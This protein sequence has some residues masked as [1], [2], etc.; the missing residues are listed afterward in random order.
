[1]FVIVCVLTLIIEC[2]KLAKNIEKEGQKIYT[3]IAFQEK[4][5]VGLEDEL[6]CTQI[7]ICMYNFHFQSITLIKKVM[8]H[9]NSFK[10]IY[11]NKLLETMKILVALPY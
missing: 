3:I 11:S 8:Y 7:F 2:K 5:Y 4:G 9:F 6:V 1:M 10:F